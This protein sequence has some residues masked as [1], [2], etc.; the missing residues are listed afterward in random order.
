MTKRSPSAWNVSFFVQNL[1]SN[2]SVRFS[3]RN[4]GKFHSIL[5]GNGVLRIIPGTGRAF[6]DLRT[7]SRVKRDYCHFGQHTRL[8]FTTVERL[9]AKTGGGK[10]AI[11]ERKKAEK[12]ASTASNRK[13]PR[14]SLK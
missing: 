14:S 5:D 4:M 9:I 8:D 2:V 10:K 6:R 13:A 7:Y 12:D 1:H 11:L 3:G